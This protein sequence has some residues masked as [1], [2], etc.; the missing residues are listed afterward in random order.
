MVQPRPPRLFAAND[1]L[2]GRVNLD[3]YPFRY[4]C[5]VPTV[6]LMIFSRA[7]TNRH[8]DTI[9]TAVE[10]LETRGWELVSFEQAGLMAYMRRRHP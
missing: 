3:H 2:S 7:D 9:L 4:I 5:L 8:L 10:L 6:P 1:V